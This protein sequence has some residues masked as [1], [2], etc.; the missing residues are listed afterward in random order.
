MNYSIQSNEEK[1]KY[2]IKEKIKRK[3]MKDERNYTER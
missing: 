2:D 1:R 3:F